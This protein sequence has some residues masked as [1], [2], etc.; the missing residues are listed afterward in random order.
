FSF[1][2]MWYS[3]STYQNLPNF[4]SPVPHFA[5]VKSSVKEAGNSVELVF[6]LV[7][8]LTTTFEFRLSFRLLT[9]L[10]FVLEALI[11]AHAM[12]TTTRPIPITPNAASPPSIHQTAF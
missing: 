3:S 8:L 10:L 1:E 7:L 9:L 2:L 12:N 5:V 4:E 11:L 6:V